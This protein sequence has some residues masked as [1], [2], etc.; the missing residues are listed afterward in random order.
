[1]DPFEHGSS[2]LDIL[3][4]EVGAALLD[5]LEGRLERVAL[6]LVG[7]TC[8]VDHEAELP[9]GAEYWQGFFLDVLN[10]V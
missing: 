3:R 9:A 8:G 7:L 2:L 6:L 10:E 5:Y 1:M 4:P